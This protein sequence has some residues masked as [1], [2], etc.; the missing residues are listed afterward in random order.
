MTSTGS[1]TWAPSPEPSIGIDYDSATG[2]RSAENA[3]DES[4][5]VCCANADADRSALC[6]HTLIADVDVVTSGRLV[7]ARL[8][9]HSNVAVS[10]RAVLERCE[11][12]GGV[13]EAARVGIERI[14]PR[15]SL[16]CRAGERREV[17]IQLT[18][19]S[20]PVPLNNTSARATGST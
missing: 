16:K 17:R 19:P 4:R 7:Q 10:G 15:L 6:R 11:P 1:K 12:G 8:K 18:F 5:F 9:P 13:V 2:N 14:G 3:R 20:E